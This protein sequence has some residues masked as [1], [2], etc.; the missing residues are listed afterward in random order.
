MK[1][2]PTI[3]LGVSF[4][5]STAMADV[6]SDNCPSH[7]LSVTTTFGHSWLINVDKQEFNLTT[8]NG[9][10]VGGSVSQFFCSPGG[11]FAFQATRIDNVSH[12][13]TGK[14]TGHEITSSLCTGGEHLASGSFQ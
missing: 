1:S 2:F 4:L 8:S 13:C 12:G 10:K 6:S 7:V 9:T 11:D 3:L 14:F 5:A